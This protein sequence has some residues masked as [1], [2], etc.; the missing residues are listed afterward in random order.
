MK[1][2]FLCVLVTFTV[3]LFLYLNVW[4]SYRFTS[5]YFEVKGLISTQERLIS[6]NSLLLNRVAVLQSPTNIAKSAKDELLLVP[7]EES[8]VVRIEVVKDE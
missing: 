7:V 2:K 8:D 3:P 5:Q 6:D 4:Q 1:K